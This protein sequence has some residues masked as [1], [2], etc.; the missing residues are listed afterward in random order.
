MINELSLI[1][2]QGPSNDG[3][4]ETNTTRSLAPPK[5]SNVANYLNR[6]AEDEDP[7]EDDS[8]DALSGGDAPSGGTNVAN[9]LNRYAEDEDP[10]EDDSGDARDGELQALDN[11]PPWELLQREWAPWRTTARPPLNYRQAA[12]RGVRSTSRL[13]TTQQDAFQAALDTYI[14]Q[15]D[16]S[17]DWDTLNV[18]Y[19]TTDIVD[20]VHKNIPLLTEARE[21]IET[22]LGEYLEL[23][24]IKQQHHLQRYA[25][26]NPN[27]YD[28][29]LFDL[30]FTTKR[31]D[32]SIGNH[33]QTYWSGP[34]TIVELQGS[35]MVK[36]I[37][38]IL[39]EGVGG[40]E[41]GQDRTTAI[42]PLI[43][44]A[45]ESFSLKNVVHASALQE[46]ILNYYRRSQRAYLDSDGT[47]RTMKLT[48]PSQPND[49]TL[50]ARARDQTALRHARHSTTTSAPSDENADEDSMN[51]AVG[52][53]TPTQPSEE[54]QLEA[55]EDCQEADSSDSRTSWAT[56]PAADDIDGP[57]DEAA[58]L[59]EAGHGE[60]SITKLQD[61]FGVS[62]RPIFGMFMDSIPTMGSVVA[63]TTAPHI[64]LAKVVD[65]AVGD[66]Y[67]KLQALDVVEEDG[68]ITTPELSNIDPYNVDYHS[69]IY[70]RP[71]TS[72]WTRTRGKQLR[73]LLTSLITLLTEA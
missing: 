20:Y 61:H 1:R 11:L 15:M 45:S 29:K 33:L 47:L 63:S 14:D 57:L 38:G 35:S 36:V 72:T 6:Y 28:P 60:V 17:V 26:D 25:T 58:G 59:P 4:N 22:T 32:T 62:R 46:T 34:Y 56:P 49:A 44:G 43:Y 55:A 68:I 51:G 39:L 65:D 24:R 19:S 7:V 27:D 5:Q 67:I 71:T 18:R 16:N 41:A 30:V 3:K 21:K 48:T 37:H 70:V 53:G 42:V 2:G 9:Y 13:T 12:Q 73:E 23:W 31:S 64:G 50:A 8:G 10:V 52:S 40:V 66:D 54:G 69:T